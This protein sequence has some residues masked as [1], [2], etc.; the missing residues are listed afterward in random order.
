[1]KSLAVVSALALFGADARMS[2]GDCPK[3]NLQS[4]FDVNAYDG[5]W[6]EIK[7]DS[8]FMFEMGQECVTEHFQPDG[9][10]DHTLYFRGWFWQMF[11]QYMGVEGK[12]YCNT[13]SDSTCEVTM[14]ESEKRVP[15]NILRTDYNNWAVNYFC[16]PMMGG[17]MKMEWL[18]ILSRDTTL[19]SS[20]LADAEAVIKAELPD[21]DIS[22]WTMRKTQQ[23]GT[24]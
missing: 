4:N 21:F 14:A 16:T 10:G 12:M 8:V 7:R 22:D 3:P 23:G 2:F 24:C 11:F 9:N 6:Y 18:N 19:S 13:G 17:T 20:L 5:K 15:F 1:M